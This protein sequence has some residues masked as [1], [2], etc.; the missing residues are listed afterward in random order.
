MFTIITLNSFSG[1]LPISSSF[2]CSC[3]FLLCSF[4]KYF[5]I[6][7]FLYFSI[8][9]IVSFCVTFSVCGLLS[10]GCRIIVLA[11]GVC[12]LVGE[13]GPGACAGLLVGG[14]GA[15][16]LVVGAWSCS[17]DGQGL[18]KWC[19]LRWLWAQYD[20]RQPVCWWAGLCSPLLCG[21][22]CPVRSGSA[23]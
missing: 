2:S 4:A 1:R 8:F 23:P 17:S 3:G 7:Y 16:P 19:V 21:C 6:V 18:V 9:S 14:T 22:H 13:V 12:P 20:F 11:S 10:S 5:S 15:C